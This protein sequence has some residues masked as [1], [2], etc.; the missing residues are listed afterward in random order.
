MVV[1]T[2]QGE[3]CQ[4]CQLQIPPQLVASVKRADDLL[5]CPYCHRILYY[6]AALH[7][8]SEP[9][10]TEEPWLKNRWMDERFLKVLS[11]SLL[12]PTQAL[13]IMVPGYEGVGQ[14]AACLISGER[15]V[16]TPQG[17][18]LGNAQA[19]QSD[20]SATENIPPRTV[21]GWPGVRVKWW[22]KSPPRPRRRGWQ[23]S[24]T[25]SKTK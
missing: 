7:E 23:G 20:M 11:A 19:E 6:E 16:R 4:G 14:V 2:V 8:T 10:A 18:V 15:K 24:I 9:L 1:A 3:T 13:R 5:T 21:L 12:F 25:R 22:G 17:R